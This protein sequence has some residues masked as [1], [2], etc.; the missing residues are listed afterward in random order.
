MSLTTIRSPP[1]LEDYTPLS[2][3]QAQTPSSFFDHKPILHYH[4]IATKCWL[5]RSQLGKLTFFPADLSSA[6]TP[7]E[8]EALSASGPESSSQSSDDTP[9][10]QK[11]DVFVNS[12]NLTLFSPQA[13]CGLTIPYQQIS[14]HAIQKI[15]PEK[16]Y[17]SVYLQLELAEGGS[18]EDFETVELTLIPQPKEGEEGEIV[19]ERKPKTETERLFEAISECSNLN[20]DPVQ[21]GDEED[22]DEDG[23]AQIIFEGEA[24]EG[25]SGVFAGARDGGL[26][27][28][29][30][31]SSGWI[32]AENVHEYF[33]EEGNWIGE[34]EEGGGGWVLSEQLGGGAGTVHRM[35][36][37]EGE[38]VNGQEGGDNNKRPK[39][40]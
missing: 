28:A 2:E 13:E 37:D 10:E 32:T 26:P 22:D 36:E 31:G 6:P 30:P 29:M 24:V 9:V 35:E 39:K 33:D 34:G 12:Q 3:H 17:S 4:G 19:G 23:G 1:S 8:S 20:P 7:P 5:S 40:E 16:K 18:E 25:F 21:D 38:Q 11:L 14:I 15:S 27:P